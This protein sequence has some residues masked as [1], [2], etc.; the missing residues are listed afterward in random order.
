MV[1]YPHHGVRHALSFDFGEE[2]CAQ[3]IAQLNAEERADFISR[4]AEM[5]FPCTV[6][7]PR[8]LTV[9]AV[10]CTLGEL[11]RS[12]ADEFVPFLIRSIE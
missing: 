5:Q 3:L 10:E 1:H 4:A 2:I 9:K 7:L 8:L 11:Q 6:E 12:A